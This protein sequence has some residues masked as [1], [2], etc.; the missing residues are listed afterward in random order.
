MRTWLTHTHH[1]LV[2][3]RG[4]RALFSNSSFLTVIVEHELSA[5][6]KDGKAMGAVTPS[7][8]WMK[9]RKSISAIFLHQ[10]IG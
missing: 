6:V 10:G 3:K 4:C 9:A 5:A 2:W 7:H 1:I 8:D